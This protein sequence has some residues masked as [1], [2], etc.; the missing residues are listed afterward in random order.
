MLLH[1]LALF[2]EE[3]EKL[4]K[5]QSLRRSFQSGRKRLNQASAKRR[6]MPCPSRIDGDSGKKPKHTTGKE[7]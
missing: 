6:M 3:L 1:E 7:V 2:K 4:K 5:M